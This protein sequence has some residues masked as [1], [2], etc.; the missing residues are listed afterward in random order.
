VRRGV[1][2]ALLLSVFMNGA[3]FAGFIFNA[4]QI[5]SDIKVT[6][7]GTLDTTG[8]LPSGSATIAPSAG[9]NY[10]YV[11]PTATNAAFF[12]AASVSGPATVT[13]IPFATA[14]S[15]SGSTVGFLRTSNTTMLLYLPTGYVSGSFISGSSTFANK[16]YA[17]FGWFAAAPKVWTLGNGDTITAVPEPGSLAVVS[18][19]V[20]GLSVLSRR[21]R[22][23]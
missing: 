4:Q 13:N 16:T 23:A 18:G 20:A 1:F 8:L 6:F 12:G 14:S 7:S 22:Q 11:G 9:S 17:D 19:L 3:A 2:A 10:V 21:R 5:G 15:S